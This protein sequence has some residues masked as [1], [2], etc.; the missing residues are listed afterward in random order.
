MNPYFRIEQGQTTPT[1]DVALIGTD[2]QPVNLELAS[3]SFRLYH[4]GGAPIFNRAAT[5]VN[6]NTGHVRYSW[7]AGDTATSG[8]YLGKFVITYITS[9]TQEFPENHYIKVTVT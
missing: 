3:A 1:L 5:V 9:Q 7:Q 8:T 4:L 2:G 6:E